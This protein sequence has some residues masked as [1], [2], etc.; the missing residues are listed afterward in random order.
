MSKESVE[1]CKDAQELG[2]GVGAHGHCR[3]YTLY[4]KRCLSNSMSHNY[5]ANCKG[6]KHHDS[7]NSKGRH[8]YGR[9]KKK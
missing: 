5:D 9:M 8:R 6:V 3:M 2:S 7:Q 1:R 4:D